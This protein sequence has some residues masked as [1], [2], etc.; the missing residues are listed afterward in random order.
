MN[1][2]NLEI[3]IL[4]QSFFY[5]CMITVEVEILDAIIRNSEK[6]VDV[7]IDEIA[8][9]HDRFCLNRCFLALVL[10]QPFYFYFFYTLQYAMWLL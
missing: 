8:F 3:N 6:K 2:Q 7:S 4:L 9:F 10:I 1:G 5:I